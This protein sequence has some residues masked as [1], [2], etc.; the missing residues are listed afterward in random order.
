MLPGFESSP[1]SP[2]ARWLSLKGAVRRFESA[3]RQG[4]RPR[5]DDHLVN[6]GSIRSDLLVELVHIDLELRLKAGE[7]A[8]VEDYLARFPELADD[9]AVI[10]E[11]IAAEQELRGRRDPSLTVNEYLQRFPQHSSELQAQFARPTVA[12]RGMKQNLRSAQVEPPPDVEGYEILSLIGRGGMGV[13]YKA[14]QHSL[15]RLVALKFLPEE[16]ARD[17]VWL[18]R[19]RREARTA[20][21]LNHPNICTIHD[22]GESAGRPYLSMELVEGQTLETLI[23]RRLPVEELARLLGQAAGALAAAHTSG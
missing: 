2:E 15:D 16:W 17:P 1:V 10:L 23:G 3:W 7:T 20:S 19:F 4:T 22:T 5:I 14:R 13:V 9:R 18:A 6:N 11:L 12:A 8:R 21:A